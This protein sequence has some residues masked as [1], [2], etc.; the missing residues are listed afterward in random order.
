M[1]SLFKEAEE[2]LKENY[3]MKIGKNTTINKHLLKKLNRSNMVARSMR[4]VY[5]V[6]GYIFKTSSDATSKG[7]PIGADQ[8]INEFHLFFSEDERV[9]EY[10][11]I[12]C[13]VYAIFESSFIYVT[14]H[15][16]LV[17]LA[18]DYRTTK[19]IYSVLNGEKT[20][21]NQDAFLPKLEKFRKTWVTDSEQ[22]QNEYIKL[23]TFGYDK[24]N[25]LHVLDYGVF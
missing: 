16:L 6:D 9:K 2:Y 8:C 5:Q 18:R 14:M 22:L 17:P 3:N 23:S 25:N 12:L 1:D 21:E 7:L 20:F 4:C 13:P 19:T 24:S 10:K 11:D 15:K